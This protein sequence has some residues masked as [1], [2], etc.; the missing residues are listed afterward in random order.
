M[1]SADFDFD[2]AWRAV[3]PDDLV[4]L[5]YTSGTTGPP[6][7]VQLTHANVLAEAL[8]FNSVV[9]LAAGDRCTSYLPHAHMA[10]RQTSH[11]NPMVFG[12]QITQ[13]ADPRTIAA[14][15]PDV[16]P[17]FWVAVPR[18][19]EKLKAALEAQG[20]SDPSALP[21]ETRRGVLAK[22]GLDECRIAFVGAAPSPVELLQFFQ[23]LGLPMCEVWGMSELTCVATCN[24]PAKIKLGT[25]GL[26]MRG[27]RGQARGRRR[28]A[29]P[30]SDPDEGLPQRAR[31][32]RRGDRRRGLDAH[33]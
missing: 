31:A 32:D 5:C 7:G 1:A 6:K 29:L 14:A 4:T 16:R 21:D 23:D 12:I 20:I 3:E 28:A 15:L 33:R 27:H 13:V 17:T 24:P 8:G 11:Y 19:W 26:P 9:A 22:I 10:D 30:W 25:V 2:A 18:V